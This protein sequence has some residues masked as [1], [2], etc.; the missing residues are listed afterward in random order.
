MRRLKFA[1]FKLTKKY[2]SKSIEVLVDEKREVKRRERQ[3]QQRESRKEQEKQVKEKERL[4]QMTDTMQ[5]FTSSYRPLI[6]QAD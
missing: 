6:R 2:T 5:Y 3:E 4:E 1:K